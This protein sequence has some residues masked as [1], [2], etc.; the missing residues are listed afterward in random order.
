MQWW[1]GT[2][3]VGLVAVL[4]CG[5]SRQ[6][7]LGREPPPEDAGQQTRASAPDASAAS[8]P[9]AR[10]N[11]PT[12]AGA[13]AGRRYAANSGADLDAGRGDTGAPDSAPLDAGTVVSPLASTIVAENVGT[14][15]ALAI[16]GA[17]LYGLTNQN[18][19]WV[20]DAGS[21]VPRLLAEDVTPVASNDC[22][23]D[24]RLALN[25]RDAFWLARSTS[26]T[27]DGLTVLHRTERDGSGDALI[28]AG[29][30]SAPYP[31]VSADETRVYWNERAE[32]SDGNPGDLVRMLPVDAAP[33]MAPTTLV[34]ANGGYTIPT[35]ALA[36][37]TLYW[38]SIFDYT[39]AFEPRLY[40]EL[41][42]D[43]LA[44][45]PPP[46]TNFGESGWVS[47]HDGDLYV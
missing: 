26:T 5:S 13:D 20:L 39:T 14:I 29:V 15:D 1:R 25:T 34:A 47:P 2:G 16:D 28:A 21:T 36:G 32:S 43:L 35:I 23:L 3:V 17:T 30:T 19:V 27:N 22:G 18:A 33:G 31:R 7:A 44:P 8:S 41:V 42:S 24:S 45:Q 46:P 37:P 40:G 9:D 4:G 6:P 11:D 10:T 38:V 12:G